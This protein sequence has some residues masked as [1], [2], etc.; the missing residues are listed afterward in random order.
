[1]SFILNQ[2]DVMPRLNRRILD[3]GKTASHPKYIDLSDVTPIKGTVTLADFNAFDDRRKNQYIL[4]TMKHLKRTEE[5]GTRTVTMWIVADVETP[6]GRLIFY[7][8]IKHLKQTHK[9]RIGLIHN[10]TTITK[11]I[12]KLTKLIHAG[13][14]LLPTNIAKQFVTKLVKEENVADLLAGKTSVADLAVHGMDVTAFNRELSLMSDEFYRIHARYATQ[15]LQVVPGG[16]AIVANG[17]VVGPLDN[18]EP[19]QPEDFALLEKYIDSRTGRVVGMHVDRWEIDQTDDKSSDMTLRAAALVAES[20]V[21]KRRQWVVLAD[22]VHSCVTMSAQDESAAAF[23]VIAIVD[24]LSREV[25]KAA[26]L[27]ALLRSVVNA[28]IKL[29][30]NPR[31]KLSELPL[32]RYIR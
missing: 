18:A 19:F 15:M 31:A 9:S 7:N 22:D 10:P 2:P 26:P 28:D 25:Q 30:M 27:L 8:A 20:P 4:Q 23:D 11:D 21:N 12:P 5:P 6:A 14:K 29:V 24:P 16:R 3:A 17:L 13:L 1:M 32:K